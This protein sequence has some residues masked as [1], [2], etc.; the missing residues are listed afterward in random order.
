MLIRSWQ[1]WLKSTGP[2]T[3]NGKARSAMRGHKGR[4]R[5]KLRE[6]LKVFNNYIFI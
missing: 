5:E 1:P 3:D 6:L 4:E 2:K